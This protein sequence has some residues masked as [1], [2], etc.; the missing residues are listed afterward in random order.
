MQRHPCLSETR[1][2]PGHGHKERQR[3]M[4]GGQGDRLKER[5]Q[6]VALGTTGARQLFLAASLPGERAP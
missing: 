2:T 6:G 4:E 1:T 5:G 3:E